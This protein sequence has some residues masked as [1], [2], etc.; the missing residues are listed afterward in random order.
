MHVLNLA[1]EIRKIAEVFHF[2]WIM[3]I[4]NRFSSITH[5]E[6]RRSLKI[7]F[8]FQW[9]FQVNRIRLKDIIQM[10]ITWKQ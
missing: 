3:P 4:S 6:E 10:E 7:T 5:M 1:T 2:G 8:S 9:N